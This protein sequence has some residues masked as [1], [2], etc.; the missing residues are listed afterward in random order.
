MTGSGGWLLGKEGMS[1]EESPKPTTQQVASEVA[2]RLKRG[3]YP[4]TR[5]QSTSEVEFWLEGAEAQKQEAP[6]R[7]PNRLES[8]SARQS[9]RSF[10]GESQANGKP[11]SSSL[12]SD[13]A[14]VRVGR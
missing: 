14:A 8:R 7:P 5:L 2:T 12:S 9:N 3:N 11:S 4:P 1:Q 6:S 13:F 10:R